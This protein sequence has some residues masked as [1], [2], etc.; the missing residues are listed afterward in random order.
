MGFDENFKLLWKFLG[1]NEFS[2]MNLVT[3]V[4]TFRKF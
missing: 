3:Y 4:S 2:C 1:M